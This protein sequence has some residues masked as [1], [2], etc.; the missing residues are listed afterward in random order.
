MPAVTGIPDRDEITATTN[1]ETGVPGNACRLIGG[2]SVLFTLDRIV[3]SRGFESVEKSL[4]VRGAYN[5]I[6]PRFHDFFSFFFSRDR[7][8]ARTARQNHR[9]DPPRALSAFVQQRV[10][11]FFFYAL[12]SRDYRYARTHTARNLLVKTSS[13]VT[14]GVL[15]FIVASLL[16]YRF[17]PGLYRNRPVRSVFAVVFSSY[18]V[19]AARIFRRVNVFLSARDHDSQP[20]RRC[21]RRSV[22]VTMSFVNARACT[23]CRVTRRINAR[24]ALAFASRVYR[25][26]RGVVQPAARGVCVYGFRAAESGG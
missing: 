15:F 20:C 2:I 25:V 22:P 10:R 7:S 6:R 26:P 18:P 21:V 24:R 13:R 16:A 3:V 1:T 4:S 17:S 14:R 9:V 23:Y 5:G 11:L 8:R 19:F 12:V